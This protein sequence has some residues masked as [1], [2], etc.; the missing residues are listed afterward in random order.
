MSLLPAALNADVADLQTSS[1]TRR[2]GTVKTFPMM[3]VAIPT[4]TVAI[5]RRPFEL[6]EFA[7]QILRSSRVRVADNQIM[8]ER[9]ET[10]PHVLPE[11]A[12]TDLEARRKKLENLNVQEALAALEDEFNAALKLGPKE[13]SGLVEMQ[14]WLAKLRPPIK[15]DEH[16]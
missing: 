2:A 3:L 13:T 4:T 15:T 1:V 16:E 5:T 10:R 12:D 7:G 9:E 11:Q 8:D 6:S 14:K